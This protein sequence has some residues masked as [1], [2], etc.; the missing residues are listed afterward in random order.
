LRNVGLKTEAE[1]E[2]LCMEYLSNPLYYEKQWF[3]KALI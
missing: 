1:L 3:F 2:P